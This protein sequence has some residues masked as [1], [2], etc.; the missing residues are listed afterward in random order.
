MT[1]YIQNGSGTPVAY[2][3]DDFMALAVAKAKRNNLLAESDRYVVSDFPTEKLEE[4]KTYRQALRDFVFPPAPVNE[5]DV[6]NEP[7]FP[8]KPE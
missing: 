3:E 4:W 2:E 1:N 7:V 6:W 5:E 8:A